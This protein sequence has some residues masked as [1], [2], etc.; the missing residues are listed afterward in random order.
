M[1]R[2]FIIG[3]LLITARACGQKLSW[4]FGAG[5]HAVTIYPFTHVFDN[6]FYPVVQAGVAYRFFEKGRFDLSQT[7]ILHYNYHQFTGS[8][9]AIISE[10]AVN[11]KLPKQ[12]FMGINLGAGYLGKIPADKVYRL[13]A[14]G[15][16][17]QVRPFLS[18]ATVPLSLFFG[19]E[20]KNGISPFIMY[21]YNIQFPYNKTIIMIP[22]DNLLAGIMIKRIHNKKNGDQ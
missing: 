12:F 5:D 11:Y 1:K 10:I 8:D 2:V 17:Y 13:N 18:M 9:L 21:S 14:E 22:A 19:Y 6:K 20:F 7:A 15:D 16:Y 4:R 3:F